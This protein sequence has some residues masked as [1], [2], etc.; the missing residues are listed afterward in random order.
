MTTPIPG[1]K[2]T[3]AEDFTISRIGYGAMQFGLF[4]QIGPP[5]NA[6]DAIA[7]LRDVVGF[8]ITHID[9]SDFYGS[10]GVNQLIR[11]ALHPYPD[12]LVIATK[13]GYRADRAG[14]WNPASHPAD[15]A[16]QVEENLD[17]LGLTSLPLVNL[18][19]ESD[20][21]TSASDVPML[22]QF[23][24]LAELRQAGLIRHLGISNASDAL[25]AEAQRIAPVVSV[26]N[27]YNLAHREHDGLVDRCA[28]EGIAFVPF[29]P[30]GGFSPLQSDT[31]VRV[32]DSL[33]ATPQQV[34]LAWLLQRSPTIALIPGT[35]SIGHLRD[36]IAAGSLELPPDAIAAL[37]SIGARP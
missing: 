6:D 18:R 15:I 33:G 29:F 28:E 8:G 12:D 10:G 4:G 20:A 26:Q 14:R 2:L 32:A 23:A 11:A 19:L 25:V 36:N 37:N 1:G 24:V 34:A 35:T 21:A 3:L 22:E 13:V 31:L 9:T 16:R 7:L 27:Y 5:E 17:H 30:L